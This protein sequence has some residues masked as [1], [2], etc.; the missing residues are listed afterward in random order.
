MQEL[1][2]STSFPLC[3]TQRSCSVEVSRS[4]VHVIRDEVSVQENRD[5]MSEKRDSLSF[6]SFDQ[7]FAICAG[8][9]RRRV[10]KA[11]Y[12]L[13]A[14]RI[15]ISVDARFGVCRRRGIDSITAID[16]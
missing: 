13:L 2:S 9:I 8:R 15:I 16:S 1:E 11:S 14:K 5:T 7:Q 3:I 4:H 10:G 12:S 6:R